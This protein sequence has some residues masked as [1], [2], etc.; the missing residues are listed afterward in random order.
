MLR[1]AKPGELK[2]CPFCGEA[3]ELYFEQYDNGGPRWRVVCA[4]CMAM[5][6]RGYDQTTGTVAIAWNKRTG[7]ITHD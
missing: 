4:R 1:R 3:I 7:G 5:I 2:P 6:D